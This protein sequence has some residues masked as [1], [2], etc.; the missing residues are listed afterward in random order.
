MSQKPLTVFISYKWEDDAHNKWVEKFATDLRAAGFDAILDRWEVRLGDS[1]TEYMTSK[2]N[3]A[4]VVLFIMTTASVAAAEAPKGEGGAVK[5]EIQMATSRKIA[6]EKMRLIGIY[7][8]GNQ[9]VAYLRDHRYADFRDDAKYQENLQELI[10]DL[11]GKDKRPPLQIR[12]ESDYGPQ[13][14]PI[15]IPSLPQELDRREMS[16]LR[17]I[18]SYSLKDET[19]FIDLSKFIQSPQ[20]QNAKENFGDDLY[21]IIE[22]LADSGYF[23]NVRKMANNMMIFHGNGYGFET[24]ATLLGFTTFD[25]MV[26]SAIR[27]ITEHGTPM[28][29]DE[30]S[31]ALSAWGELSPIVTLYLLKVMKNRGWINF[32]RPMGSYAQPSITVITSQGKRAARP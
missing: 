20:G 11:S 28:T 19:D 18:Y 29:G 25:K 32:V 16:V 3:E 26:Y 12:I 1:F 24:C 23:D 4:D 22:Y 17:A 15:Q 14:I 6:G 2:I 13:P 21:D 5:F 30:L 10:D 8:E 27:K 9:R 31:K 7:R